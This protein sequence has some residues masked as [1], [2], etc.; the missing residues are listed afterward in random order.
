MLTQTQLKEQ[1]AQAAVQ[2]VLPFLNADTILGVG[3]GSTVDCFIDALIPHKSRFRGTVSSSERSSQRLEAAGI[4]VFDLN[5]VATV[6]L[7]IDGADEVDHGFNMIKGGGGALTREK[8]V[9]SIAD[10]YLCIVDQSKRVERLGTFPVPIEVIPMA[11]AVVSRRIAQ[12]GGTAVL[13]ADFVTDN[14]CEILDVAGMNLD[15]PPRMESLLND[16]PGV[17]CC[18]VFAIS[19]ADIVLMSTQE[20]VQRFDHGG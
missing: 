12:L 15:D 7:Y 6:P 16:I 5:Q 3:T 9:A 19:G 4:P 1:V 8:I 17:V 18:G 10:Q 2:Y 14:G 20:G 13:R 11:R